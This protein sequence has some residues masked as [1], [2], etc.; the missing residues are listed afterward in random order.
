MIR[1]FV[2]NYILIW[3]NIRGS[4]HL[5]VINNQMKKLFIHQLPV[6]TEK[7]K[8]IFVEYEFTYYYIIEYISRILEKY[9]VK[10]KMNLIEYFN[11]VF[12]K[13]IDIWGFTMIYMPFITFLYDKYDNLNNY[14]KKLYEKLKYIFIHFLFETPCEPI[15]THELSKEL[16]QLNTLFKES[17][18]LA[19]A[20][21]SVFGTD[22][23]LIKNN[24]IS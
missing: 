13:N 2:I 21:D 5:K 20:S 23:S 7:H 4:G 16:K 11:N 3:I 12:I 24:Y 17:D 22:A 19:S 10:N 1:E 18:G 15:N 8:D 9:T 6:L 14:E